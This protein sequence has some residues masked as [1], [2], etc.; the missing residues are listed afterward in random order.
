MN[1]LAH[2]LADEVPQRHVDRTDRAHATSALLAPQVGDDRLAM[3]RVPAHQ[4]RLEMGDQAL[5]IGRRRV[6]GRAQERIALDAVVGADAQQ[7]ERTRAR[8]AAVQPVLR[9]RDIVPREKGQGNVGD[10]HRFSSQI[11]RSV[12]NGSFSTLLFTSNTIV[13][14]SVV[15]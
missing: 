10:L 5:P 12:P 4:H 6:R 11:R 15:L 2:R 7:A 8:K 9:R 14:R 13:G 3:H 1:R